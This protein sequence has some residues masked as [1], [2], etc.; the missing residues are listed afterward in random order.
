MADLHSI[1]AMAVELPGYCA[2]SD[3]CRPKIVYP[4]FRYWTCEVV[5]IENII[6]F[7]YLTFY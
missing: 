2:V 7:W 5:T 1:E 4:Q 6:L 3:S